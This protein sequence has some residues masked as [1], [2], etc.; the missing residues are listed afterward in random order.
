MLLGLLVL[1]QGFVWAETPAT[2]PATQATVSS[3]PAVKDGLEVT[4]VLPKASFAADEPLQFV[5]RL[6]NVSEKPFALY[7]VEWFWHWTMRFEDVTSKRPWQLRME[8]K[9]KRANFRWHGC[10]PGE[11]VEVTVDLTKQLDLPYS[12]GWEGDTDALVARRQQLPQGKYRLSMDIQLGRSPT[13]PDTVFWTGAIK[14]EPVE[15]EIVEK[16]AAATQAADANGAW[17]AMIAALQA[18]DT[19]ALVQTTTEKGYQSIMTESGKTLTAEAM[20]AKGSRWAKWEVRFSRKTN[21][22]ATANAAAPM[23]DGGIWAEFVRTAEGWK[24]DGW[25]PGE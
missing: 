20:K 25:S 23:T 4:V 24:I 13:A 15:F 21:D 5:V 16:A 7:D 11:T 2:V 18:G 14:T 3:K 12:F 19:K 8:A 6:K 22:A 10:K 9:V 17:K 1:I